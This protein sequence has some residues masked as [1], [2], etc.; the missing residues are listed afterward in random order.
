[1]EASAEAAIMKAVTATIYRIIVEVLYA[2]AKVV[3][4]TD[5]VIYSTGTRSAHLC[6]CAVEACHAQFALAI[7]RCPQP[8]ARA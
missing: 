5:Q 7:W 4:F 8:R 6:G 2:L 1:M 3:G